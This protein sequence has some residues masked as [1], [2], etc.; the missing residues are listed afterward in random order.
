MS[1]S[2]NSTMIILSKE[3]TS[4]KEKIKDLQKE[5]ESLKECNVRLSCRLQTIIKLCCYDDTMD[6]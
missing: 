1:I 6:D 2:A 5:I 4:L 3:N